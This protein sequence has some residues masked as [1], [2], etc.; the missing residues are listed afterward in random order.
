M[1]WGMAYEGTARLNYELKTGRKVEA[2]GFFE[3]ET[4]KAG[5]SPDGLVGTEGLLEIK[6]LKTS[7]HLYSMFID[8]QYP[9][10]FK[11]Q[12]M[13]QLWVTGREWVDFVGYDPRLPRGLDTFIQRVERD[14]DYIDMME[15][16]VVAFLE[17]VDRNVGYFLGLLPVLERICRECG[18]H[19]ADRLEQCNVCG[20]RSTVIYRPDQQT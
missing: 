2:A 4:L 9:E 10:E 1:K 5:A 8:H 11:P 17:E 7:N 16:E 19:F 6:C 15:A 12:V 18:V 20:S 14:Q 3:H 13:M